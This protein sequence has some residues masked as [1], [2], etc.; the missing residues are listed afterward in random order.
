MRIL[1]RYILKSFLVNYFL[2]LGVL[3]GLYVL[4]DL[5]VNVDNFAKGAL[6]PT[7][8]AAVATTSP[9]TATTEA[10]TTPAM[11]TGAASSNAVSVWDI[12]SDMAD[13]YAY[14]LLM[15]FQQVSGIIPLLAAGFTM[16]RM[17]RHHEL[18]A[19]LSSGVSLYRVAA[20]IILLSMTFSALTVLNQ[21]FVISQPYIIA[22]LLRKHG[23]VNAAT[24]K[25]EPLIFLKD[26]GR[27]GEGGFL[28][29]ASD[30]D[31]VQKLM[32]GVF[33]VWRDVYGT[34]ISHTLAA[35]AHWEKDPTPNAPGD[36]WVMRDVIT[37]DDTS[38][39]PYAD[40]LKVQVLKTQ[41]TPEQIDLILSKKAVDFLS[42]RKV[43][44][45][46][47]AS[48][49]VNR[50]L[51]YKIMHLR[52]TQPLMNVIMLLIGIPFLLTREP[53]RLVINMFWCTAVSGMI[54]IATFVIFQMGGIQINPLWAAWLPVL[55]FGPFALVM[56][57][58]IKT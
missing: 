15:I 26:E 13:Y 14:Q 56:M 24:T 28:L 38:V 40:K 6:P 19:M 51:L 1:D 11:G 39:N 50:P 2:A 27:N 33:V 20:P 7:R 22:K 41:M 32:T 34:P 44:E 49:E 16:V 37:Q 47:K 21:E 5:I 17:T 48:P 12:T 46:A 30:Y 45:L 9:A 10:V 35:T 3:V 23:E 29:S 54:F 43:Q 31:P 58:A 4:L 52:F 55:V 57:D 18:T 8:P 36:A 42:S 25:N 53:N